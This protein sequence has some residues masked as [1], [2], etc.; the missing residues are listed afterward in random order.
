[1]YVRL[2]GAPLCVLGLRPQHG[3]VVGDRLGRSSRRLHR[4]DRAGPSGVFVVQTSASPLSSVGLD[5]TGDQNLPA[6]SAHAGAADIAMAGQ[7]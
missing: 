3:A 5:P 2:A 1:V 7:C 4:F 6:W